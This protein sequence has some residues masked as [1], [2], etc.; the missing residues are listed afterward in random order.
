MPQDEIF[1]RIDGFFRITALRTYRRT[2]GV[3]FDAVPIA[4]L[5][6]I[7]AI[8]RVLHDRGA[9][10]PGSVAGVERPWYMHT[11]QEDNL[12]VLAGFRDVELFHD[13]RRAQFRLTPERIEKDGAVLFDRPVMLSWSTNVFHRIRSSEEKGSASINLAVRRPWFDLKTEF[14]IYD[15]DTASG[16]SLIVREGHLDQTGE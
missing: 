2:A 16:T 12:V 11:G 14:N 8:D 6:S 1:E 4:S 10:S 15:L 13:G 7:G 3:I 5:P 9:L